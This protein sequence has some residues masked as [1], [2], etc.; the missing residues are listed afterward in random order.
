MK[1][2]SISL[3]MFLGANAFAVGDAVGHG[4]GTLARLLSYAK[5][6]LSKTLPLL[7]PGVVRFS[8]PKLT[9]WYA[10]SFESMSEE[11]KNI[12]LV[13]SSEKLTDS[14]FGYETWIRLPSGEAFVVEYN[15][16]LANYQRLIGDIEIRYKG[17]VLNSGITPTLTDVTEYLLHELGHRYG[18][19]EHD[20]W[21]FAQAIAGRFSFK[22]PLKPTTCDFYVRNRGT[23][24][25]ISK[26]TFFFNSEGDQ[27]FKVN[28]YSFNFLRYQ[29][30]FEFNLSVYGPGPKFELIYYS[31]LPADNE[32]NTG[33]ILDE[34]D[35]W[36]L[37]CH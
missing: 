33:S 4:G 11:V 7:P 24:K 31:V 34:T 12:R 13:A 32:P 26:K 15:P 1:T 35:E 25:P 21:Q 27:Q 8:S 29:S 22:Q 20:S 36:L 17:T 14:Y 5:E 9:T 37:V 2:L 28:E 10:G 23:Y 30:T 18:L 19:D 3:L 6:E 16:D